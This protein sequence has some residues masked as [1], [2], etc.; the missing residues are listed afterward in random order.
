MKQKRVKMMFRELK[1]KRGRLN[2]VLLFVEYLNINF[3]L[4]KLDDLED[5]IQCNVKCC[6]R[7]YDLE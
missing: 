1:G 6:K 4:D 3:I 2:N 5:Y 7:L